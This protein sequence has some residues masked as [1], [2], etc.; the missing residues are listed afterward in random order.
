MSDAQE[1]LNKDGVPA[2]KMLS[3]KEY[4]QVKAS[5]AAKAKAK[6][7]QLMLTRLPKLK[8]IPIDKA[9]YHRQQFNKTK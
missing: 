1:T 6:K 5:I 2:G 8:P 9:Y 7:K 4:Q 3:P